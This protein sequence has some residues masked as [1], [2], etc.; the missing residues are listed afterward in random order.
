MI[1]SKRVESR[2]LIAILDNAP[3]SAILSAGSSRSSRSIRIS[4]FANNSCNSLVVKAAWTS[5][6]DDLNVLPST[7]IQHF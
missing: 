4:T 3:G 7:L 1:S 2:P 5:S 6:S